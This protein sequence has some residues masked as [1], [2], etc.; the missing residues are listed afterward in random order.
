[1]F[2]LDARSLSLFRVGLAVVV[3]GDL[4]VRACD[5]RTF[6]SDDGVL[7]RALVVE[8]LWHPG[9]FSL[10]LASGAVWFEGL[11]FVV[12]AAFAV[13][14]AVGYRTRVA[15]I[16]SWALLVSLQNRNP[17]VLSSADVLLRV[18]LFWAMFLP[19]G[20]RASL[21]ARRGAFDED[22]SRDD[23]V[24][25]AG[26]VALL[27]QTA[28]VYVF[29]GLMKLEDGTWRD[30]TGL[31]YAIRAPEFATWLSLHASGDVAFWSGVGRVVPYVEILGPLLLLS[32]IRP[33]L[34][35]GLAVVIFFSFH[36]GIALF[37]S[38][39]IFA[40]VSLV[41]WLAFVPSTAWDRLAFA[42][43]R[44]FAPLVASGAPLPSPRRDP[45]SRAPPIKS[46][47]VVNAMRRGVS[48]SSNA[49]CLALAAAVVFWNL[50]TVRPG[51]FVVPE[52]Q[53][54]LFAALRLDQR[55]DMF[56]RPI[57]ASHWLV[58]P[59]RLRSGALVDLRTGEPV[60]WA[61]PDV[62]SRTFSNDRW[63]K[64]LLTLEGRQQE[65][66]RLAYARALCN[67]WNA[68][69]SPSDAL[70][71]FKLYAVHVP[72]LPWGPVGGPARSVVFEAECSGG[73]LR[74]WGATL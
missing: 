49:V 30:G 8:R 73:L 60:S 36:L 63:R 28:S 32:P 44:R 1:M 18:L 50:N 45:P 68:V 46:L 56:S 61:R 20:A 37:M 33:A 5:L 24:A 31:V 64:Y 19:L 47:S 14:L 10:H 42:W 26:T 3:L 17:E 58:M 69:H 43:D 57:L 23:L 13:C 66:E 38:I 55:W 16:A 35:K 51:L 71:A 6:Y 74:K 11:L 40:P 62:V 52:A 65:A 34:C 25:S 27:V 41:M 70:E 22:S 48:D 67:E 4:A 12:A 59:A 2:G 7:P 39:G 54:R 9:Y 29:A 15:T 72:T 53:N 21:D